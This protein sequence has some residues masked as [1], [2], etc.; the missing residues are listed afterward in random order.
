MLRDHQVNLLNKTLDGRLPRDR[1]IVDIK[2]KWSIVTIYAANTTFTFLKG[3]D[4][5][6]LLYQDYKIFKCKCKLTFIIPFVL[7]DSV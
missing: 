1:Y 7:R 4:I 6:K 3:F 2:R 5:L